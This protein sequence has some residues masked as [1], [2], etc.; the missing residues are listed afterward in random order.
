MYVLDMNVFTEL[1]RPKS[2]YV[3]KNENVLACAN[4]VPG[5]SLHWK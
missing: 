4:S 2:L 3:D 5:S 1:R